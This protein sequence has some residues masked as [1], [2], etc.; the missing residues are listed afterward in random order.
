MSL[1]VESR[2]RLRVR[3]AGLCLLLLAGSAWATPSDPKV[4]TL[5]G[6]TAEVLAP[7]V[8]SAHP[9]LLVLMHG[10]GADEQDL[11]N[12]VPALPP[13]L[14]VV[15]LRAPLPAAQGY[16]WYDSA[17]L[18]GQRQADAAS[19]AASRA[20]VEAAIRQVLAQQ[21]IDRRHVFVGGFSQGAA[22]SYELALHDPALVRGALVMSGDV[23]ADLRAHLASK[24][25]LAGPW[26]K[27]AFA[28][29][30]GTAD[31][32]IPYGHAQQAVALLKTQGIT[33]LFLPQ[34]GM[35]HAISRE[36]IQAMSTWLQQQLAAH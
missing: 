14:L 7:R 35:D 30:H 12:L 6:L 3:L 27:P 4:Q 20:K 33:P 24:P 9:P 10:F 17:Q 13:Q 1:S 11:L 23:F 15:S 29:G 18:G 2:S 34:A 36:E 22:M 5:G 21:P 16:S 25:T 8:P 31:E 32:R 28:I 19:I 26:G